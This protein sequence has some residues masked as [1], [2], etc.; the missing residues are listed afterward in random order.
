[1]QPS[2]AAC[3]ASQPSATGMPDAS[4]TIVGLSP[5]QVA[6]A[7]NSVPQAV[8]SAVQPVR[9]ASSVGGPAEQAA[10]TTGP[11]YVS[12]TA[13]VASP[14]A[15]ASAS[16]TVSASSTTS[17]SL[18]AASG[19]TSSSTSASASAPPSASATTSA[20]PAVS[21]GLDESSPQ[22]APSAAA[23]TNIHPN[24]LLFMVA[25]PA[26]GTAN[27]GR[28]WWEV[29]FATAVLSHPGPCGGALDGQGLGRG[30]QPPMNTD[31]HRWGKGR[32][33]DR[34]A[35]PSRRCPCARRADR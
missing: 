4:Q 35:H 18:S 30:K 3:S 22:P 32:T 16:S 17:P 33:G 24:K 5:A 11:Q 25:S 8:T 10:S 9:Q 26:T 23:H 27:L 13:G 7:P 29:F 14:S 19:S 21:P 12:Q 31:E 34:A 6:R 20:S 1:M 2:S 15:S 28:P